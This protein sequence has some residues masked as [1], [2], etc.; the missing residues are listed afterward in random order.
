MFKSIDEVKAFIAYMKKEKV[1]SF[2]CG[3]VQIDL[4]ALALTEEYDMVYKD[5]PLKKDQDEKREP[6]FTNEV[7]EEELFWSVDT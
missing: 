1:G 4:S 7:D 2:R 5:N 6:E 3:E